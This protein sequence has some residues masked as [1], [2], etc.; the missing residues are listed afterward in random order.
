MAKKIFVDTSA[1]VALYH[2]NDQFHQAASAYLKSI[3]QSVRLNTSN[4]IVDETITRIRMQDGH[5]AAVDFGK[6]LFASS[7]FAVQYISKDVEREAFV[8]FE[9]YRDKA[10][11]FTDCTSFVLMKRLGVTTAFTFDDDFAAVG[12][13][14]EP[15][16]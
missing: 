4:Y 9:K 11:S 15:I 6:H 16:L 5:K 7:L 10:L 13:V 1:F 14:V 2:K 3:D 12:F 8:L